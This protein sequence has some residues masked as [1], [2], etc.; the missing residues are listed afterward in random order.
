MTNPFFEALSRKAKSHPDDVLFDLYGVSGHEK[1]LSFSHVQDRVSSTA[2]MFMDLGVSN[3]D[4]VLI[5]AQHSEGMLLAFLGAQWM[6]AIPAF[7][8]PPT[9]KQDPNAWAMSH[10]EL[11]DRIQP[12]HVV[13]EPSC[14]GHVKGL[15]VDVVISTDEIERFQSLRLP[16]AISVDLDRIAF[17]QHSSGTTGL[18]KG[19]MVTYHQLLSQ[20]DVYGDSIGIDDTSNVVSWLPIYHDMGLIAATLL[21]VRR[22][23]PVR[24]VDTFAW[25]SNPSTLISL[26]EKF[27][28]AYCWLPNF[29]FNYLS[30][31]TRLDLSETALASVRAVINCSE[32]CKQD[33]MRAFEARFHPHGLPLNAVQVCYAAA[34]YVFAITQTRRG[35]VIEGLLVDA[36]VLETEKR[37]VMA[38][39]ATDRTKVIVPVGTPIEGAEVRIGDDLP[40]GHV[41]EVIIRGPSMCSGYFRNDE[42]TKKKFVGGWYRTGDLG[43]R[44]NGAFYITGRI[45]DL[46]I[47]RGKNLYA[48]DIEELA[49]GVDGVKIGRATAF[50]IDDSSGTQQLILVVEPDG[51]VAPKTLKIEISERINASFGIVPADII[52]VRS[53]SLVKTTSGKIS[54]A[55]NRNRY[56]A[57]ALDKAPAA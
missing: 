7:M 39:S 41:G 42:T 52:V 19:V 30:K 37:V 17:L 56:L 55:E 22:A 29:A 2:Q 16:A 21:P 23:V 44:L 45:D 14:L 35:A 3:G 46:V 38:H 43:F 57:K 50:G 25:L 8:P 1:S 15:G 26:L 28:N 20:L 36:D 27:P 51:D 4:I 11:I 9:I 12:H 54:R 24:L 48:H 47:V 40:D 13:S 5:F 53:N 31:R 10:R 32:P 34:E 6:G 33:D 18:K 49:S